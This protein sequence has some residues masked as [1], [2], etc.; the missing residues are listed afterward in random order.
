[1]SKSNAK[2]GKVFR[3]RKKKEK[4]AASPVE[5]VARKKQKK[6]QKNIANLLSATA[7]HERIPSTRKKTLQN[8]LLM[9]SLRNENAIET[10]LMTAWI[11]TDLVNHPVSFPTEPSKSLVRVGTDAYK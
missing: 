6:S 9:F 8:T 3:E 7:V 5:K 10:L 1:M 2:R 4:L 11:N